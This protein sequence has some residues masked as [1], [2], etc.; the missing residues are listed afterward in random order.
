MGSVLKYHFDYTPKT[1]AQYYADYAV[2]FVAFTQNNILFWLDYLEKPGFFGRLF[3]DYT[4]ANWS[5]EDRKN[6]QYNLALQYHMT[7]GNLRLGNLEV[8][9]N[10]SVL[11]V[12][13][14]LTNPNEL[15]GKLAFYLKIPIEILFDIAQQKD[16]EI[17]WKLLSNIPML[18]VIIQKYGKSIPKAM[19]S[20]ETPLEQVL[21]MLVPSVFTAIANKEWHRQLYNKKMFIRRGRRYMPKN[22]KPKRIYPKKMYAKKTYMK[23][24]YLDRIMQNPARKIMRIESQNAIKKGTTGLKARMIPTSYMEYK[25]RLRV[26][27]KFIRNT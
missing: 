23:K 1:R 14:T 22:K 27:W 19:M 26:N 11:D 21:V 16:P 17:R 3:L 2:P 24:Q 20:A 25:K 8:K 9:L 4:Q 13:Q 10:L 6:M 18:G 12:I 15:F 5:I 7:A